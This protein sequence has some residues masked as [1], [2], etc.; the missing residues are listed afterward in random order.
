[1]LPNL[2]RPFTK[3]VTIKSVG[4]D[5]ICIP[6]YFLAIPTCKLKSNLLFVNTDRWLRNRVTICVFSSPFIQ[7]Y[8]TYYAHTCAGCMLLKFKNVATTNVIAVPKFGLDSDASERECACDVYV[9][10]N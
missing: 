1:M 3:T 5:V 7:S 6:L 4:E 2:T 8:R 10:N 9:A